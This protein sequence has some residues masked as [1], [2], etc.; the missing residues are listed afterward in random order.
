VEKEMLF[1]P[2]H[3]KVK[4]RDACG[5]V[6][7]ILERFDLGQHCQEVPFSLSVG[8][9]LR[10]ALGAV[11]TMQQPVLL[12][13]EPTTGQNQENII[14]VMLA[15]KEMDFIK[16]VIFCTHDIHTTLRYADRIIILGKG[17]V[18]YDGSPE[19][20]FDDCE[21]AEYGSL[22]MPVSASLS[23]KCGLGRYFY[24]PQALLASLKDSEE[25]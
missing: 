24:C 3:K 6:E 12:L 14:K 5:R 25:V 4:Y 21:T 9:R 2:I 13:D 7:T 23:K 17:A 16:T 8:Q 11:L 22:T 1:G 10:V 20:V 15:V 18:I 19:Q